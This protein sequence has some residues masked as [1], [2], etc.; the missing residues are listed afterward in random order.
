MVFD[1]IGWTVG[2]VFVVVVV[3]AVVVGVGVGVDVFGGGVVV[4]GGGVGFVKP[5]E[6]VEG[7]GG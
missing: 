6:A 7:G 4:G 1:R 5:H 2:R 3:V